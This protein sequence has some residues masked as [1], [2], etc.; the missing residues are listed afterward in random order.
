VLFFTILALA[1]LCEKFGAVWPSFFSILGRILIWAGQDNDAVIAFQH[2][3]RL[4]ESRPEQGGTVCDSCGKELS[5]GMER[6][7]CKACIDIDLCN[8][9]YTD[10]E[11]DR[12][13]SRESAEN[14][15]M[16]LFLVVPGEL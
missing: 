16:H 12:R 1:N 11:I 2:Q 15:Q 10:Y 3:F 8:K 5:T 4:A 13:I 9:C 6:F 7:V 14:C